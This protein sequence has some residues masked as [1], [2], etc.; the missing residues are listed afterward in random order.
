MLNDTDEIHMNKGTSVETLAPPPVK[1][2]EVSSIPMTEGLIPNKE[3]ANAI[4]NRD[5]TYML[6]L[7]D[8]DCSYKNKIY[9]GD[10]RVGAST[11]GLDEKAMEIEAAT[12]AMTSDP[13][14]YALHTDDSLLSEP[15]MD[16]GYDI[17][18]FFDDSSSDALTALAT[19]A[20]FLPI[21]PMPLYTPISKNIDIVRPIPIHQETPS[22]ID[23]SP[24]NINMTI[25]AEAAFWC[26]STPIKVPT[27]TKSDQ[28]P[29]WNDGVDCC[30]DDN[31]S[32][33]SVGSLSSPMKLI[34]PF[35]DRSAFTPVVSS[36]DH[37]VVECYKSL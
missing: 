21:A 29:P 26:S 24:Q 31:I 10:R 17:P 36:I 35:S 6:Q 18:P 20:S 8:L 30:F 1:T 25:L 22:R 32:S 28:T 9:T 2:V 33:Y 15:I 27:E 12:N 5:K 16:S 13:E 7:D 4:M 37:M 23:V 11:S 3:V 34:L 14:V 19:V